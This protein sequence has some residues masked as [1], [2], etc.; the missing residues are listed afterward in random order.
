MPNPI[1]QQT[2]ATLSEGN[3]FTFART[4]TQSETEAFGDLTRDYNPVH[5]EPRWAKEKGFKGL[6]CHGLLIGSM[7]C[8]VGGQ[9]GWLATGMN[10]KFIRP[11]YF[12][13]TITCRMVIKKVDPS[14]RAAAEATFTNQEEEQVGYAHLTGIIPV[15]TDKVLLA[16]MIA[17][18]DPT[19]ELR[20]N[21]AYS[22]LLKGDSK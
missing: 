14:G 9:A 20:E 8:E 1:R 2:A 19:N 3:T 18:G 4:F 15:G 7:I 11:V 10:F 22:I 6:I 5:Y 16:K 21:G 12:G 17:E 13:D